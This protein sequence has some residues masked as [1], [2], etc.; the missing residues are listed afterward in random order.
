MR[1]SSS[2]LFSVGS[3]AL[4][5]LVVVACVGDDPPGSN[6]T[7]DEAGTDATTSSS[8]GGDSSTANDAQ[9]GDGSADAGPQCGYPGESCC[10]APALPCKAGTVCGT[11][12]QKC[13]VSELGVVGLYAE[14]Q[15]ANFT[16]HLN[17]MFYD[18]AN[19]TKGPDIMTEAGFSGF[20]NTDL[21]SGG[22]GSYHVTLVK[23]AEG[24]MFNFS[25]NLWR[26]CEPGQA[27]PG[28]T[29]PPPA[30]W[31]VAKIANDT[32][33]GA[34]NAI[35]RCVPGS[36]CTMQTT[37]LEG[38]TWGTG[39]M[40]GTGPQDIWFSALTRA[41]H[42]DG[43][44]WTIHD[45]IKA[46]TIYQVRKDDVWVGDK[47]LQHWDGT[48]WSD[49]LVIDG[50]PAPGIIQSI[51]GSGPKDVWAAGYDTTGVHAVFTAHWDGTSWTMKP[52]P[53]GVAESPSIYAPSP[54]EAF[55]ASRTGIY[56]WNGTAWSQMTL[57]MVD[58]GSGGQPGWDY[59]TGPAKPRP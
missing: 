3:F 1:R 15:G 51:S 54:I 24:K 39:K 16:R 10:A 30:F 53:A 22:P 18:G 37:G 2:V 32:W 42:Y 35:Y 41:F 33:I 27:C 28:P 45:N 55:L 11:S 34:T 52:L 46:R 49:E 44:K 19:W 13:M 9:G 59:I 48:K 6:P 43:T 23:S 17:S 20:N 58:A 14:I 5:T 8:S 25:S 47:T 21:I 40:V 57:P 29:L 38:T 36:G 56:K 26:K 50:A 4:A 7:G 31:S 12:N